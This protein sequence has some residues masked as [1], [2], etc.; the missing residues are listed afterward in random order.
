MTFSIEMILP[1]NGT[2]Y[3]KLCELQEIMFDAILD[4]H[5]TLHISSK[6]N[7]QLQSNILS[8]TYIKFFLK[9]SKIDI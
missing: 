9:V 3:G 8:Q 2:D 5:D 1:S 6:Y 7:M 4:S